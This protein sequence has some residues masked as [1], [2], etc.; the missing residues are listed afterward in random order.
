MPSNGGRTKAPSRIETAN[1]RSEAR[2]CPQCASKRIGTTKAP[3]TFRYGAGREAA[4]ITVAVDVRKCQAC[5]L[6]FLDDAAEDVKHEAICRHLGVMTP[7]EI[8]A[9]RRS[10]RL[11]RQEFAKLTRLG[12]ATLGRWERGA[13]VQNAANDT[14]LFLLKFPDNLKRLAQRQRRARA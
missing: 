10:L 2:S 8:R 11:S 4:E 9:L 1:G 3:Y 12:E 13:L 5:G 14:L 6:Q 7:R